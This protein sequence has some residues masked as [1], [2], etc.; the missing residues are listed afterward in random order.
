MKALRSPTDEDVPLSGVDTRRFLC[1]TL[2]KSAGGAKEAIIRAF[3][4]SLMPF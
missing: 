2:N 1:V 4:V 3:C